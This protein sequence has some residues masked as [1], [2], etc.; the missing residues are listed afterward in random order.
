MPRLMV[1]IVVI[2]LV[3]NEK[4]AVLSTACCDT[5][6]D[7]SSL[8]C[9]RLKCTSNYNNEVKREQEQGQRARGRSK[10]VSRCGGEAP[11]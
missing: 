6:N 2:G 10:V 7:E 8:Y 3:V 1:A 4:N 9:S 11:Y 5:S